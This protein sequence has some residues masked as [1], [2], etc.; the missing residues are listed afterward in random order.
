MRAF[1]DALEGPDWSTWSSALPFLRQVAFRRAPRMG[2]GWMVRRWL[3]AGT[4][5]FNVGHSNLTRQVLGAFPKD[6]V[7]VLIHD[8]IPLD[9]PD[10]QRPGIPERFRRK[11]DAVTDKAGNI[12]CIS[13]DTRQAVIRHAA[14]VDIAN[15]LLVA[16]NGVDLAEPDEDEIPTELDTGRP[17]FVVL[18]TIEPRKNHA[19]L[20]DIWEDLGADA[21]ALVI[22]G[23]RGWLNE[24]VFA[25]LDHAAF[26]GRTVFECPGL[27][28]GAVAAL[29]EKSRGLLFPSLAE[30]FGLPAFEAAA[31]GVPVLCSPLPA[32]KEHL[33]SLPIYADIADKSRWQTAIVELASRTGDDRPR[34][35]ET[36][37]WSAH[38]KIALTNT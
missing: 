30:G 37:D 35:V 36:P 23:H 21:P 24:D 19:L 32:V 29:L 11:F 5:Y 26:M 38:F 28:D 27:S 33:G 34:P 17:F 8:T 4:R 1:A 3:P 22:C 14:Q 13:H 10:L 25:R 9:L 2:L 16:P 12:L 7:T 6:R 20:L 18:G 15:G 31:R